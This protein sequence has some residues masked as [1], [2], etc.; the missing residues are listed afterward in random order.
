M[1]LSYVVMFGA[2]FGIMTLLTRAVEDAGFRYF[3]WNVDSNDAG[4]A[5]QSH[6][7]RNNVIEGVGKQDVSGYAL[8]AIRR[9]I[10]KA[11][12]CRFTDFGEMTE[13]QMP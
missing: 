11:S 2:F 1:I 9:G 8:S 13:K 4:G 5:R 7:V 10:S 6:T 3:D 12:Y